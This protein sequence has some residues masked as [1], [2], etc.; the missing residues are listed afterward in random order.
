MTFVQVPPFATLAF[1][2][3]LIYAACG[4]LWFLLLFATRAIRP[5]LWDVFFVALSWP[6]LTYTLCCGNAHDD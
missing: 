6:Y 1:W 2:S 3:V 4:T 5:S